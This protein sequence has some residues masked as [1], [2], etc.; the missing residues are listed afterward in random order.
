[1]ADL[2]RDENELRKPKRPWT[3]TAALW[4]SL[5]GLATVLYVIFSALSK[6]DATGLAQYR[7]G[8]LRKLEIAQTPRTMPERE[9]LG[10][11]GAPRT[12]DAF[13][14]KVTLVNLWATWCA[15]C[16][17]EMPTLAALQRAIDDPAFEVA[18]ISVDKPAQRPRAEAM[19][20]K[21][22]G[23]ALAFYHDPT[24]GIA[25]ALNAPGLPTTVLYD[26]QGRELARLAGEADWS[27]P[28]AQGLI[29]HAL[30]R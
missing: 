11:D 17:A 4:L 3:L 26:K 28:E 14:G 7:T 24:M 13:K 15:P 25:F 5:V 23:G 19:L 9:F 22:G 16:A 30:T 21:L 29:R 2:A 27:S 10:P 18:A 12:M 1:M 8:A 6:P 20:A